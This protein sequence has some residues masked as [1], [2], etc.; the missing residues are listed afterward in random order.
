MIYIFE[1][2]KSRTL[3]IL[4]AVILPAMLTP[5]FAAGGTWFLDPTTSSA[6]FFHGPQRIRIQF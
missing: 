3:A 1:M 6:R 2:A 4:I 5:A